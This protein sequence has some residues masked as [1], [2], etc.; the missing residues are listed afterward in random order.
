[1]NF[2]LPSRWIKHLSDAFIKRAST[3]QTNEAFG[4]SV[5]CEKTNCV[6]NVRK[7]FKKAGNVFIASSKAA[8]VYPGFAHLL[9]VADYPN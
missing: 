5:Q 8:F 7:T 1:M 9:E 3:Y 6:K 2:I 4:N